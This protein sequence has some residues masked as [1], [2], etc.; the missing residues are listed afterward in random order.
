MAVEKVL[1]ILASLVAIIGLAPAFLYLTPLAQ[2]AGLA[3]LIA[4]FIADRRK[5]QVL[6]PLPATLLSFGC[7]FFYL[8]QM[9]RTNIVEPLINML[10]LLLA[11]RLVTDKSGRN[12][13]QIFVLSTFILAA[14]SLLSLSAGYLISLILLISLVTFGLLL[15]S[16]YATDPT[17]QLNPQQWRSLLRTGSML[18]LGSLLLMLFFFTLLPRTEHPLWNFL[19][20]AATSNAGFSEEVSPGSL[21]N[22]GS[23]GAAAFR[24]EMAA[25][26]PQELYWRGLV[27]NQTDGRRWTRDKRAPADI[28]TEKALKTSQ[29][30]F[31][32]PRNDRYLPGLDL[33][34]EISEIRNSVSADGVFEAR[35]RQGKSFRYRVVS[36]RSGVQ[37]IKDIAREDFYLQIPEHSGQ[38][39]TMI[40]A[41]IA[42]QPDRASKIRA[43][44]DF[45]RQQKLSYA[46]RNLQLS[47]TPV[48]TFLFDSKR[49]YCEYFASSYAL[50]LRISGVP[51]RLV[52]GY[53]GGRYNELGGYYLV[54]EDMAHVWVE[55]L[56]DQNH[57]QRLDPSRLAINAGVAVNGL[58]RLPFN[59][60]QTVTDFLDTAWSRF[61]ITYDLQAQMTLLFATGKRLHQFKPELPGGYL[62]W[63][64]P[65]CFFIP[66]GLSFRKLG[67]HP[68]QEQKIMKRYLRA[69]RKATGETE[70][71]DHLGLFA[72][73]ELSQE[74][75]C[76]DF[77]RIY[78]AA[79][80]RGAELDPNEL[81][82][83]NR[84]IQ[85][86]P[87]HQFCFK[88]VHEEI[89]TSVK[90][91]DTA[92]VKD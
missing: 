30:I 5:L 31:S 46:A 49:G 79:L 28:N 8:L 15:T 78:G 4:G 75:L 20:P 41:E 2:I 43:A 29:L 80:Y 24:V 50:L 54:D 16:F 37:E 34:I 48:E 27:L 68:S 23:S 81:M 86:I 52:G 83:L 71:P 58:A 26:D 55:A 33:P 59:W 36:S 69:L 19:N 14:S 9:S 74:P 38:R 10:V 64:L 56:D 1:Q 47:E 13:L 21:A 45:F 90:G 82:Q 61:V 88:H 18:P 70:I 32:Q 76:A 73:A 39:L 35:Y 77:A 17:L 91:R 44:T 57:W 51:T 92:T 53:L 72:I 85:Q 3:A 65:L 84:I 7:F 22:L 60:S 42:K 25:I 6:R 40:A 67:K 11:V 62:W 89:Y 63:L 12:L 66:L 87:A